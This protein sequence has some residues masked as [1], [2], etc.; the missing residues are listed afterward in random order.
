MIGSL[1]GALMA[2]GVGWAVEGA[3]AMGKDRRGLGTTEGETRIPSGQNGGIVLRL[4]PDHEPLQMKDSM[5][6]GFKSWR[7]GGTRYARFDL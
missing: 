5:P 1:R 6:G 2:E 7:L 3:N 4:N